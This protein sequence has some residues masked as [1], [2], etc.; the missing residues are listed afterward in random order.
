MSASQARASERDRLMARPQ[1]G[2]FPSPFEHA[3]ESCRERDLAAKPAA[4]G[5][6]QPHHDLS[7]RMGHASL[8]AAQRTKMRCDANALEARL[9]R[10]YAEHGGEE[11][12][13]GMRAPRVR[14]GARRFRSLRD[15]GQAEGEHPAPRRK[16]V[17]VAVAKSGLPE[18]L[19]L[20]DGHSWIRPASRRRMD[21][22]ESRSRGV[23]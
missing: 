10:A 16:L 21:E 20:V 7:T 22:A 19:E 9:P 1:R 23:R 8:G 3:L 15:R 5:P 14:V 4:F 12:V 17:D 11:A 6:G 13:V 2:L 18:R